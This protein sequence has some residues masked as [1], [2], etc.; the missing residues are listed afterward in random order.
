MS[1][2]RINRPSGLCPD[3]SEVVQLASASASTNR[4]TCLFADFVNSVSS[5]SGGIPQFT[6]DSD[7]KRSGSSWLSPTANPNKVIAMVAA[8]PAGSLN[9]AYRSYLAARFA[10]RR[11]RKRPPPGRARVN[12]WEFGIVIF[13]QKPRAQGL[14]SRNAVPCR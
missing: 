6:K 1:G 5:P 13:Q 10:A 12:V 7:Y 11:G 4:Q 14:P 8:V 2:K 9:F 3:V